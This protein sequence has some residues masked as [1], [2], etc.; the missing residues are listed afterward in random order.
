MFKKEFSASAF[1]IALI[2]I[3]FSY[4]NIWTN[5]NAI[6]LVDTCQIFEDFTIFGISL[7]QYSIVFFSF[8]AII[9]LFKLKEL[10]LALLSLALFADFLLLILMMLIAPCFNC[11]IIALIM[12][13]LYM[14]LRKANKYKP[15]SLLLFFWAALFIVNVGAVVK[16]TITPYPIYIAGQRV[17]TPQEASMRIYFSPSCS[18][19]NELVQQLG[20]QEKTNAGD[21]A[22]YPVA[23]NDEDILKV[24][25][26][27]DFVEEGNTL[28]EA[29]E[30]VNNA[31][32]S[33]E[34]SIGNSIDY[35]VMQYKLLVNQSRL[36][37]AGTSR[38]PFVEYTGIPAHLKAPTGLEKLRM[39]SPDSGASTIETFNLGVAGF[40]DENSAEPC[41]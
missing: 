30:K 15:F 12:A 29:M 32:Y 13:I 28:I 18:S 3:V 35:F 22:W 27:F 39:L 23:E 16:S 41:E 1:F 14:S 33:F 10:A 24:M 37:A 7:W 40:C 34:F 21:I 20:E 9:L 36:S 6:C 4:W 11:L 5:G 25:K 19:C 17:Q 26:M 31:N 8:I 38:I 2:G